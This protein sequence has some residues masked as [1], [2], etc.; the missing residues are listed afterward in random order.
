MGRAV[1]RAV[2]EVVSAIRALS[3]ESNPKADVFGMQ[4]M[5]TDRYRAPHGRSEG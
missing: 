5:D 4:N 2:I 1:P 3:E